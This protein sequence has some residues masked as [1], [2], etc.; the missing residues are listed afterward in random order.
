MPDSQVWS[1]NT[2]GK[3]REGR[4]RRERMGRRKTK[5][6]PGEV[7]EEERKNTNKSTN[8]K[9]DINMLVYFYFPPP[10]TM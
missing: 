3:K 6:N 2:R 9:W 7:A 10:R 4:K 1:V 5:T 8:N